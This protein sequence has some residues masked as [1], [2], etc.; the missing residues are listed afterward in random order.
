MTGFARIAVN[1]PGVSDLF[2][3]RIPEDMEGEVKRGCLAEVPFGAQ[4][5]QGIVTELRETPAV[6]DTKEISGFLEKGPVL[7][8]ALLELAFTLSEQFLQPLPAFISAMLPPG[9]SQKAD[10]LYRLNLPDEFF[11][12]DLTSLQKRLVKELQERGALRGRQLDAAFRHVNWRA[13]ARALTQRG[14]IIRKPFLPKPTVRRKTVR[15]VSLAIP[16]D[17]LPR[18]LDGA[19]QQGSQAYARR[20]KA[21]RL[22]SGERKPVDVS[23]VYASSGTNSSD[24][25]YLEKKGFIHFIDEE[26]WR[27]PLEDYSVTEEAPPK[28]TNG[29]EGVWR[30]LADEMGKDAKRPILLHGVTGSG[31]TEIYMRAIEKTLQ[32]GKQALVLV[33]EISLTPQS[34]RRFTARFPGQV[35]VVHSKLSP[36][37]RY[38]TW[39]RALERDFPIVIGPRSA[40]FTPFH[41]PGVIV[42]DECH[43]ES[44]FQTEMAP[45]YHAVEAAVLYGRISGAAVV[46]GSATPNIDLYHRAKRAGWPVLDLPKRIYAYR[47]YGKKRADEK[48]KKDATLPLP[49]V[50]VVDMREELKAGNRSIFSRELAALLSAAL[51]RKEQAIL[52]LNR[53][54]SATYVFCRDCG[55]SVKCP[56]CDTPLTAHRSPPGLIC[57]TCGYR[58]QIPRKCPECGSERIRQ[59]GTGTE[60]VEDAL[61]RQFPGARVLRWDAD[62]TRG[63]GAEDIILTHF[64][65]HNA[66][67]LVGTQMLA[68]GLDLPLVT[69]VGVVLA[70][71][72]LNFPDYRTAERT[73]QLLTQVAGR[74]GRSPLGGSVVIQ[75]FNP[76]HYA[77]QYASN[78][79]FR[80]FYEEEIQ[81]RRQLRYPP[82]VEM[83]RFEVRGRSRTE[84]EEHAERLYGRLSALAEES[85]NRTVMLA[86][87]TPP[88]FAKRSGYYR[89]QVVMK[90]NNLLKLL[91]DENFPDV[92]VEVNPPSLL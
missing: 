25:R 66:D 38:D 47:D 84:A 42:L 67:I 10:S 75:S 85:G 34:I 50:S 72:G 82:F 22:L 6:P 48:E 40:L 12:D 57:H 39:R 18:A 11:P 88:Y 30:A 51:E 52:L 71:P 78:H 32:D 29:Q 41:E 33:P 26:V 45:F 55:Y 61:K 21:L 14:L 8:D 17:D 87:P 60:K 28:L 79:D 15:M 80:G 16:L 27:D 76:D 7:T 68:K 89:W 44:Y 91:K 73:F 58:R 35:G 43:D 62:T 36:G 24:L 31:K 54:G 1:V 65:Q 5:V 46:L 70:D 92:R 59:Y 37:E 9:L 53:R 90:G 83:V 77:I 49:S 20:Q 69:L 2:D 19:G 74:A 3:Y 86:G 63:K 64:R 56:R 23:W 13:S 81:Y 4:Q